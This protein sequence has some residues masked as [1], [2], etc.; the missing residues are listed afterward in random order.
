MGSGRR[1]FL[2]IDLGTTNIK[3]QI[4]DEGGKIASSGSSAVSVEHSAEGAA[5]QDMEEIWT[6]TT[7]AVRQATANG[8]GKDV[9]AIGI[10]SQGGALQILDSAGRPSGKVIG[11]Q[12]SRGRPWDRALTARLGEPWF[13]P[14]CGHRKSDSAVGQLQRLRESRALPGGFRVG[15]VGDI[16][17][18]RLCGRRAHDATSLSEARLYNPGKGKEDSDLLE[19]LG[20]R[21]EDL[22]D[23][24]AADQAAGGLL[25]DL[26]R[27]LG[28]PAGI[29]V[30]PAVHDQ[31]A[32]ALGSGVV[33]SGDTMLGVGTAWVLLAVTETLEPPVMEEAI[34]CRHPVP[35]MFGQMLSMV[36][37][38]SCVTWTLR[39]LDLENRDA[40]A[41][42]ALMAGIP[43]GCDGLRFRPLLSPGTGGAGLPP[44]TAGRIDGL[45]LGHTAAHILR[46]VV[47]GLACELGR[48][49]SKMRE[50]G[51][52]ASRLVMCGR[53]AASAVTP[54]IIADTTGLPVDCVA[55]P[56]TSSLGA[57]VLARCLVE[58]GTGLA[59][60]AD[61]M[62]PALRRVEPGA[63][64]S[65]ARAMLEEYIDSL[66]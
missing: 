38:G 60:L 55:V 1:T 34:A 8:N 29:P 30:G 37:G 24:L 25:P 7:A 18:G 17:V 58:P 33:R 10:S 46:A 40:A 31:Y 48:Y 62:R 32:A 65:T 56:E 2:G 11:W 16:V 23:L 53:A 66:R 36:N 12:D 26:A 6:A 49:L 3:A 39:T 20:V 41:I 57:A 9:C 59:A 22:P 28:L 42:D 19:L 50:G 43:P 47:E 63:G 64:S 51:V 44:G 45:R 35:G 54:G 14:R 52:D 15:W 21:R 61:A 5:E 4:V 13:I 27:T